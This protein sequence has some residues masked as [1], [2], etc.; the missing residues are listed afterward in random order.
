M[1]IL[2]RIQGVEFEWNESKAEINAKSQL[3]FWSRFPLQ[4]APSPPCIEKLPNGSSVAIRLPICIPYG[5]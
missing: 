3:S 5:R 2:Y 1:D 4:E